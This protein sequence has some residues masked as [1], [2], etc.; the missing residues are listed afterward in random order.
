MQNGPLDVSSPLLDLE[1]RLAGYTYTPGGRDEAIVEQLEYP[2]MAELFL[3]LTSAAGWPPTQRQFS[4]VA[5][6]QAG[7]PLTSAVLGRAGRAWCSFVVQYH[8]KASLEEHYPLVI[9]DVRADAEY[10][11]DLIV[12][13]GGWLPVALA[14]R[15]D[16]GASGTHAVRKGGRQRR[17]DLVV[18]QVLCDRH[19]HP[20]G[21]FWLVAQ[22]RLYAAAEDALAE[23]RR[24]RDSEYDGLFAQGY[25]LA[26]SEIGES[27]P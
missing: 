14:L 15:V 8:A 10:G 27:A 24:L 11:L 2:M 19:E 25:E 12:F 3:R 21:P 7:L 23:A 22:A 18:R 5:A 17:S 20:V 9:W 6:Y 13:G 4:Y 1:R 26:Y 16:G